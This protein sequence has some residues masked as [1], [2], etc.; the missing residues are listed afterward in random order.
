MIEM[1]LLGLL[2]DRAMHGYELKKELTNQLGQF[3][4]VSYGSLY[5]TI[6]RLEKT[7]AVERVFP[8]EDVKRRKNI[9][10]ITD[11]GEEM[12]VKALGEHSAVDDAKFS[13]KLAFFRY[14]KSSD[15]VE[16]LERRRAYLTEK[17]ADMR[18]RLK[19]YRERIDAYTLRLMEHGVDTTSADI[20]WIETLIAE[21][22][23]HNP[24]PQ[25][26]TS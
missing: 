12:F 13:M 3:W 18:T 8:K 9:Y 11:T 26:A 15:R 16:L 24:E 25:E 23:A 1:A 21:E 22:K 2:K 10:R 5:P 17:L 7:G 14:M 4:Q 20:E 19:D 6:R